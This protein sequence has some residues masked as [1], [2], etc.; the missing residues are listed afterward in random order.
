MEEGAR[1]H[2]KYRNDLAGRT[3]AVEN[4]AHERTEL[5]YDAAG[6]LLERLL[7]DGTSET[8]A[9]N[10]RGELTEATNAAGTHRFKRDP[11]GR[12]VREEQQHAG[13]TDWVSSEFDPEGDRVRRTTSLGH[14]ELESQTGVEPPPEPQEPR[15]PRRHASKPCDSASQSSGSSLRNGLGRAR[16]VRLPRPAAEPAGVGASR[17]PSGRISPGRGSMDT[18][19]PARH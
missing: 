16:G 1:D 17:S 19:R 8:F 14:E 12:I 10:L 5:T 2:Q 13:R 11:L 7:D 9:Y 4:S 6:Q 18:V 3:V 15:F